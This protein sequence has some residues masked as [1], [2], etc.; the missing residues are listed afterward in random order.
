M[1]KTFKTSL[2]VKCLKNT[3]YKRTRKIMKKF[4]AFLFFK[5]K[6]VNFLLNVK[7]IVFNLQIN[8]KIFII[9]KSKNLITDT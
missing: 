1:Y 2:K 5:H 9:R 7:N 6:N 3:K 8:K 4:Y